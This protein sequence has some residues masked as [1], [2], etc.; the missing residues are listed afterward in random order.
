M[1]R[2]GCEMGDDCTKTSLCAE[3]RDVLTAKCERIERLEAVVDATEMMRMVVDAAQA[4]HHAVHMA[5]YGP[6]TK[7]LRA[8]RAEFHDVVAE[9]NAWEQDL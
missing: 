9:F 5:H 1:R 6:Y 2:C 4:Y 8:A 7:E 3:L